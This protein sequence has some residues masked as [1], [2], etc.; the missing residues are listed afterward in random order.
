MTSQD[1]IQHLQSVI[2]EASQVLPRG[3]G[4]KASL[5]ATGE[6]QPVCLDLQALTGIV[7]YEPTEF[8]ITALAGTPM[9][10]L[11]AALTEHGQY[12]PCDPLFVGQG[13]TV[14]GTL[15][16]GISGPQ[17]LLHGS[18]RDFVM[19]VE[20]IDGLGERV[21]GG[22]KVVKNAAGFDLPKLMVGSYGR[23]GVLTE[24][25]LKVLPRPTEQR[26]LQGQYA[27][28]GEALQASQSLLSRPL[29]VAGLDL[30]PTA[31]VT[32]TLAG[33]RESLDALTPQVTDLLSEGKLLTDDSARPSW[34]EQS[35][36]AGFLV[37]IVVDPPRVPEL[38][39]ILETLDPE[40]QLLFA[41]GGS[42]AWLRTSRPPSVLD[43][44]LQRLDCTAVVVQG[45]VSHLTLPGDRRWVA[46]AERIRRAMDPKGR[47]LEYPAASPPS[48]VT[49]SADS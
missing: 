16:S 7:A 42:L 5:A 11:E 39:A 6:A 22:G 45:D 38:A 47:F 2:R 30:T 4:T 31:S 44:P 24:V 3:A 12:L 20:L 9:Q 49:H 36:E 27:T 23:L 35:S 34:L 32:V 19:E 21:R 43:E 40:C 18:L 29:P 17:K 10:T 41:S 13:A 14:G 28:L 26:C 15:A 25:T 46:T 48:L 37:R 8:L 33:S 1:L